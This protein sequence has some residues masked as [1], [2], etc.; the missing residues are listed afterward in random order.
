MARTI[1]KDH[2]EKRAAL[3]KTAAVFFSENGFDRASM[4][5]LA[6]AC[7]VSKALIY[8]YYESK[9]ALLFDIVHTH[10]LALV[11]AVEAVEPGADPR[12]GLY[13]LT[14]AILAAYRD[15]DAE[16]KVQLDAIAALPEELQRELK[17]L[18]RRLVAIMADTVRATAPELF[19]RRPDLLKPAAMSAFGMLNWF[20]MWYRDGSGIGRENYARLVA[21]FVLGG[22]DRI[23][24]SETETLQAPSASAIR[25]GSRI[26]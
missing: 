17:E 5:Q 15:A 3:L 4:S 24:Q 6:K 26:R 11:E 7:G 1:A 22:L 23:A 21:D 18:Q 19:E 20:Y 25:Q 12:A 10:L 16:H 8:H 9:D 13:A 2:D 14:A